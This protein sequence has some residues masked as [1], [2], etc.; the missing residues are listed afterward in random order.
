MKALFRSRGPLR[1]SQQGQD[2]VTFNE[3]GLLWRT[4]INIWA[5]GWT[6][7]EEGSQGMSRA[8][9]FIFCQFSLLLAGSRCSRTFLRCGLPPPSSEI[10]TWLS[11]SLFNA[12][13][14]HL[15]FEIWITLTYQGIFSVITCFPVEM[16]ER[17]SGGN[18]RKSL[19]LVPEKPVVRFYL[20]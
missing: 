11:L 14:M 9:D 18:H 5:H 16:L 13:H 10:H 4:E 15:C 6:S 1:D 3:C 20:M 2:T 8:E 12:Y 17:W 19:A 7:L